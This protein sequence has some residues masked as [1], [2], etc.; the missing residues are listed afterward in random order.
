MVVNLPCRHTFRY[1]K[2]ESNQMGQINCLRR[3]RP[4]MEKQCMMQFDDCRQ[5]FGS[6]MEIA[7]GLLCFLAA[8]TFPR[9]LLL[10]V[11]LLNRAVESGAREFKK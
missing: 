4:A 5:G 9:L 8:G 11:G 10:E 1:G 2:L 3:M 6:S 7:E